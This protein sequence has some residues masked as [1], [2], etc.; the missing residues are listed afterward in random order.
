[1][2][3]KLSMV[4]IS[5][6][7]ALTLPA[8]AQQ[9]E[10]AVTK[11]ESEETLTTTV[12][13]VL[14]AETLS[15]RSITN[16]EDTARYIPGVQVNDTGNRFGND[17]FNI[18]G[19]EGDA[20][21]VT[22]DGVMQG[23]TLNPSTFAAYGMYGSSRGEV[24]IEHVKAVTITKGPSAVAQGPGS[25]AGSVTYVTHDASDFL[26]ANGDATGLKLKTG[27][28]GRSDEWLIHG[29]IANRTG[30][31]ESLVQY[32]MR[33]SSETEAHGNGVNVDGAE[34]GQADPMDNQVDAALIKLAYQLSEDQQFGVVYEKTDRET[35]GKPLSRESSTYYGFYTNDENNRERIGL[36]YNQDNLDLVIADSVDITVNYQELF[37]SGVTNFLYVSGQSDPILRSED[38]N[39][40]QDLF[41]INVD[42]AKSING[43]LNHE[44]IYGLS[45]QKTDAKAVMFDRRYA[46]ETKDAPILDGYPIRDQ[47]FVPESEKTLFT[48][49]LADTVT[50]SEQLSVNAGLRYDT[51]EYTP[52]V[53]STF[54][55]PTGL[56]ISD[57]KFSA[58]V[59][60]IGATYTFAKGHSVNAR[61]AQGYQAPTLQSLYFGT[62]S[63][64]EVTDMI[65]GDTYI[66]LDR[67]ANGDLDAQE[68]TNYEITYT[69]TFDK[70]SVSVSVFRTDYTN[71]I[72]D[73]TY[74][75]PYGTEVT[76]QQCSRFGCEI[77]VST[78]DVFTQPQNTG[79][80]T[81][82]GIELT[83]S[84]DFTNNIRGQLAYTALDG[85]YDTASSFNDAGDDLETIS[86]DTG[87]VAL[88]YVSDSRDW[89]AELIAIVS[90]GVDESTQTSFTA[91]NNGQGPAYT[92]S[93]YA[94]FD[95]T[96]YYDMTENLRFIAAI[97]N[98]TDK[99]YYRWEVLNSV[100][101]GTG[102]FFGGVSGDGYQR[103]SEPGRSISAYVT[104]QF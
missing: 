58:V 14:D 65:T 16:I 41:S 47:S 38:R 85:T 34:R 8:T 12:E 49:Y 48:A 71:M 101:A 29:T 56:S 88:A 99:E 66:D 28:D 1:M 2:K 96:A 20:V 11:A 9:T 53:D 50:L 35:N 82:D 46:G 18:R 70:G 33:D 84:Y 68:S 61:I 27:F 31:L 91:L 54:S 39:F 32:T 24:E 63:G 52:T 10:L 89:G 42:L 23:E 7:C 55:D 43:D 94:V 40:S 103:F 21:A 92:P 3:F 73:E 90:K 51:T 86:P 60:E 25:L 37:S 98:I 72:Q 26:P 100:R 102:G 95:L 104:Y 17:G 5:L 45:Y 57:S 79:E 62:N 76:Q 22:V 81:V 93:G 75:T 30:Q 78:E 80:I 36:F 97:Y 4:A 64:D 13:T 77:V 59:G 15:K 74:S 67:I 44:I 87:T 83:A 69:G 19:L 6:G